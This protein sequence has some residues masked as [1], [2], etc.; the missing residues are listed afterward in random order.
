MRILLRLFSYLFFFF[1]GA[2]VVFIAGDLIISLQLPELKP[3]HTTR[4][5]HE[6]TAEKGA[7]V[8]WENYLAQEQKLFDEL[9]ELKEVFVKVTSENGFPLAMELQIT[10]YDRFGNKLGDLLPENERLLDG[11]LVNAEGDV[12]LNAIKI[13]EISLDQT[14]LE[15]LQQAENIVIE[16]VFQTSGDGQV[17]VK[18]KEDQELKVKVG[19]F[20]STEIIL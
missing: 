2:F 4:L 14:T 7:D 9:D 1:I 6:F 19:L 8:N 3:W 13:T 10:Y 5:K 16:A 17:D 20:A 12:T 15:L 11:A 18:I